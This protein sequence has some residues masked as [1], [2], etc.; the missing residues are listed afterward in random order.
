MK[1]ARKNFSCNK[2]I[3]IGLISITIGV[4]VCCIILCK[5]IPPEKMTT[6]EIINTSL[7]VYG[8][9]SLVLLVL[10]LIN[11]TKN[12][13][14]HHDEKRREKT[15]DYML[16]WSES[17]SWE[18][19]YAIK[20]VETFNHHQCISL[21]KTIPFEVDYKTKEALCPICSRYLKNTCKDCL[22]RKIHIK[23]LKKQKKSTTPNS[24]KNKEKLYVIDVT[25]C[26]EIRWYVIKYLNYLEALLISWKEGIVDREI[27][28]EQFYYLYNP[29]SGRDTLQS[30]R[31]VAGDGK[32]YP[33]IEEFCLELRNKRQQTTNKFKELL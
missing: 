8:S 21:Y 20:I 14:S 7:T 4:I 9:L 3:V 33:T 31:N 32:S 30:F 25:Q 29:I 12:A 24:S 17:L 22:G 6:Y 13:S 1:T 16:K 27:I 2:A 26:A 15:V 23:P 10:Q 28:E 18:T 19:S 5:T 11:S